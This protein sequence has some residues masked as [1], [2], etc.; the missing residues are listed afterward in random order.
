MIQNEVIN[1]T[2]QGDGNNV[3]NEEGDGEGEESP[4]VVRMNNSDWDE[5]YVVKYLSD[6]IKTTSKLSISLLDFGGNP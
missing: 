2:S 5:D 6:S 4:K 3:E 1:L